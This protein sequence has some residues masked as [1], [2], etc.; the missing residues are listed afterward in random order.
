MLIRK[1]DW[2]TRLELFIQQH[3]RRAFQYGTW[4]C[5]L[6]VCDAIRET[7][8]TDPAA[9]YRNRYRTRSEAY[10]AI[11]EETGATSLRSAVEHVT[12]ALGMPEA[13]SVLTAHRGDVVLLKRCRDY[14][15]GL[16]A[17]DGRR[18]MVAT[19][20]GLSFI[21]LTRAARAWHV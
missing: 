18:I 21:P 8:G 19:S 9:T 6:F 4:D 11:C 20:T 14:S 2:Q 15:L 13:R 5:C 16:V 17:L 12:A 7:T 10:R 3:A 1:A